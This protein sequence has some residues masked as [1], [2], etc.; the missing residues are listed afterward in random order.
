MDQPNNI[1][2]I[3]RQYQAREG[4]TDNQTTEIVCRYIETTFHQAPFESFLAQ[5][6]PKTASET[7]RWQDKEG[8]DHMIPLREF[9]IGQAMNA[10]LTA[11]TGPGDGLYNKIK[12]FIFGGS[13]TQYRSLNMETLAE[14]AVIMADQLMAARARGTSQS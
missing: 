2:D 9:Y 4:W 14:Q 13:V 7:V 8:T 5:S 11:T 12:R 3:V 6:A 1:F 10:L